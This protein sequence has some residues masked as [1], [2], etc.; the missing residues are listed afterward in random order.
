MKKKKVSPILGGR[1]TEIPS[2]DWYQPDDYEDHGTVVPE[3][4]IKLTVPIDDIFMVDSSSS[5]EDSEETK[6][7]WAIQDDSSDEN[8]Y[9]EIDDYEVA[10]RN[11]E[12]I[13]E[14]AL[15]VLVDN[16]PFKPGKY[17]VTCTVT[18]VYRVS[19]IVTWGYQVGPSYY[20]ERY[21]EE[22]YDYDSGIDTEDMYVKLMFGKCY[23]S[24]LK[25]EIIK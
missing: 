22:F 24:N 2:R 20:S 19:D 18:L 13:I 3:E 10:I 4:E 12:E 16:M 9:V 1:Y 6:F 23:V 14:D 21:D 7:D 25:T 17:H 15:S 8:W 5:I 11:S